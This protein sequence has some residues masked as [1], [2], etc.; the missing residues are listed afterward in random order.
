MNPQTDKPIVVI[1]DE[2][3]KVMVISGSAKEANHYAKSQGWAEW[4]YVSNVQS[5]YGV[6]DVIIAWC[7]SWKYRDDATALAQAADDLV[8]RKLATNIYVRD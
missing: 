4:Q 8:L 6:K 7:G 1:H 5:F 2:L 3:R